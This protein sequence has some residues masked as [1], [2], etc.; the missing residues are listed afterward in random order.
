MNIWNEIDSNRE[1]MYQDR[2]WLHLHP[3]LSHQEVHTTEF[4]RRKLTEFGV[5]IEDCGLKTGVSA[6]VRGAEP[7]PTV[8]IRQDIDALPVSEETG[9][10]FASTSKG[11]SHACGHDLHTVILLYCGK[12]LQENRSCLA[13]NVRLLFQPA[14]ETGTGAKEMILAGC[15]ENDPKVDYVVG[16]HTHPDTPAGKICIRKGPF[17]AGTDNFKI[18]IKGKGGHGA[19]PYRCID[20]IVT[21]AYVITQLQTVISRT[22]PAVKPAVLSIGSIHGG[23]AANVIPNEVVMTGN[24]RSFYPDSRIKNLS[25]MQQ[26]VEKVSEAMGAE[27]TLEQEGMSLPPLINDNTVVDEL[28]LA[29]TQS[30]GAENIVD[31]ELPSPGSDDFSCYLEHCPGAQF[32]IGTANDNEQSRLGLH[33]SKVIFDERGIDTGVAVLVQYVW[34]VLKK[35][36]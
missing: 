31:L 10:E 5:E 35:G 28:I 32:F 24:L 21:A 6:I 25:M 14:E 9:L 20:P 34:N 18:T 2:R 36:V 15:M 27:G 17:N 33:N 30:I 26:I 3:E 29:A 13:G 19:H 11:I 22:N 7:G 16:V 8:A 12:I 23:N 4:I 1:D